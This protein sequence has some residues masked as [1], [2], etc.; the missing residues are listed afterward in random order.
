[1]NAHKIFLIDVATVGFALVETYDT[2][3]VFLCRGNSVTAWDRNFFW[4]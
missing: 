4:W 2:A 1:L 3:Y